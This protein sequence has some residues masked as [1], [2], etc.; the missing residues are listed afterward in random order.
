MNL[1]YTSCEVKVKFL[2]TLYRITFN[3]EDAI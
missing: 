3:K 1:H 2:T